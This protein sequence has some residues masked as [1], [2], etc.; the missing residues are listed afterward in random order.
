MEKPC[1]SNGFVIFRI[2]PPFGISSSCKTD[3]VMVNSLVELT[4]KNDFVIYDADAI[5]NVLHIK[6]AANGIL[7]AIKN[8]ERMQGQIFNI[9]DDSLAVSKREIIKIISKYMPDLKV[10]FDNSFTDPVGRTDRISFQKIHKLGFTATIGIEDGIHE[11]IDY[12]QTL[13]NVK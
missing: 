2:A 10:E 12:Y 6:D 1:L 9:G 8:Y 3:G 4:L 13:L 11:L 5:R 7:F